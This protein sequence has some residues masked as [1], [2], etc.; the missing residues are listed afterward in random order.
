MCCGC[1]IQL[2][3]NFRKWIH[4]LLLWVLQIN[5][6]KGADNYS[7]ITACTKSRLSQTLA[8]FLVEYQEEE[9]EE[10]EKVQIPW[11]EITECL[12]KTLQLILSF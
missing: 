9:E 10:E 5:K 11:L 2:I 1:P 12:N 7:I 8:C 3:I 4:M 6:N